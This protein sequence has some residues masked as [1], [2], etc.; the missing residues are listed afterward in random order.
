M[1]AGE[2][3]VLLAAVH[4][5][6]DPAGMAQLHR[7]LGLVRRQRPQ[8]TVTHGC[9]GPAAPTLAEAL[10]RASGPVVVV[11]VLLGPGYHLRVDIPGVL[12]RAGRPHV[13]TARA[14][15]PDPL[16][17]E[18]LAGRLHQAGLRSPD[19][20]TG[21]VL[22]AAGSTDPAAAPATRRL[23]RL[24]GARLG[25][26]VSTAFLGGPAPR[27]AEAVS[28]LRR[29]GRERVALAPCL[30]AP[31]DF[32]RRAAG[33]GADITGAPL[34]AHPAVARLILRRYDEALACPESGRGPLPELIIR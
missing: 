18:A 11:P 22:A 25:T 32:A 34:G 29:A 10:A 4:G 27:P 6:R 15:G 24:L 30:L 23:A 13:R 17:A 26:P 5:T 14:L 2:P 1:S 16:L 31:G 12:R 28:R 9:L 33:C 21:V 20:A 19:P 7:L 3:P 8:L